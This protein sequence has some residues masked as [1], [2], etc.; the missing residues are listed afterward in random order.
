MLQKMKNLKEDILTIGT[1]ILEEVYTWM[2]TL[3]QALF[4]TTVQLQEETRGNKE[5]FDQFFESSD[6]LGELLKRGILGDRDSKG[7][8]VMTEISYAGAI[9]PFYVAKKQAGIAGRNGADVDKQG[10]FH[11]YMSDWIDE[12]EGLWIKGDG[13]IPEEEKPEEEPPKK[14]SERL[15]HMLRFYTALISALGFVLGVRS[16]ITPIGQAI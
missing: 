10:I 1:Q 15:V 11:R 7:P 2:I 13:L 16:A 3:S 4:K 9:I 6:R 14:A 5:G 8:K 12:A